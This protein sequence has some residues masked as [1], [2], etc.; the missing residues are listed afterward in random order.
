M[1]RFFFCSVYNTEMK[2]W[3]Q[4]VCMTNIR[5]LGFQFVDFVYKSSDVCY[6]KI[7]IISSKNTSFYLSNEILSIVL[8][9][10]VSA[11]R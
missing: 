8:L 5:G 7:K 1:L 6:I 3:L 4:H 9:N 10:M 11:Q 2:I